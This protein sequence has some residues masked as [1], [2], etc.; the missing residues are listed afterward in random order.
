MKTINHLK[1]LSTIT[2]KGD[3]TQTFLQGQLTCDVNLLKSPG[4]YSLGACCDHKG[5]MVANFWVMRRDNNFL[6]ILPAEMQKIVIEHLQ[7]YAMFSKVILAAEDDI[8]I[9]A[10]EDTDIKTLKNQLNNN[11]YFIITLPN[12]N[13]QIVLSTGAKFCAPTESTNQA[14][15]LPTEEQPI[16]HDTTLQSSTGAQNFTTDHSETTSQLSVGAQNF[17]TGHSE[18]TSQLSVGAQNFAPEEKWMHKNIADKLVLLT[19]KTSLLFTPQMISLEQQGGVSFTKGCYVG[20]EIVARTQHLGKLKR[21]L[22]RIQI[23]SDKPLQPGDALHN[24][25]GEKVGVIVNAVFKNNKVDAL[26]VVEDRLVDS[27]KEYII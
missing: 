5:R 25:K 9:Y 17:T 23:E 6:L 22:H 20:Q 4:D 16:S 1:Q 19:P 11:D 26:A 7:K 15:K 18:T 24:Q 10:V 8:Y 13:R 14:H 3:N 21:H 12:S 27:I 2:L